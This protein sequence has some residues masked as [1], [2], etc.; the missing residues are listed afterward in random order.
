MK[1]STDAQAQRLLAQARDLA[2]EVMALHIL[3]V[4]MGAGNSLPADYRDGERIIA[5]A[6]ALRTDIERLTQEIE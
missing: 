5:N 4:R 2:D 3:S 6:H 1:E